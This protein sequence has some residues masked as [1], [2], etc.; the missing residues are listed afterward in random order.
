MRPWLH[1]FLTT[2]ALAA[3]PVFSICCFAPLTI[4]AG[5]AAEFWT[6]FPQVIGA[7]LP[8]A[9]TLTVALGV[10]GLLMTEEGLH[11]YRATLCALAILLWLQGN[12]L[13]WDYGVLDG[14]EIEWMSGAWRG[15]LDLAIWVA[16][17]LTAIYAYQRSGRILLMGAAATLLIQLVAAATTLISNPAILYTTN[18]ALHTA[19]R[20]AVMRFSATSNIVHIVMDGFQSDIFAEIIADTS[21]RNLQAD[22]QGFTYFDQNLG[23]YPYTQLTVPAMLSGKL[24]NNDVPVDE[25]IGDVMRGNT[26]VNTAFAAGYEVDIAAPISLINVYNQGRYTNAYGISSSGHVDVADYVR[27]DAAKLMDLALFRVVPHVGKALVYRDAL[28]VFQASAHAEAYLQMQYFSDLAFL[29][30]L[31]EGMSVDRDVPVYKMIHVMLSHRPFVGNEQ[32]E[33]SGRKSGSRENVRTHA[34]CGLLRVLDVLQRM[35]ELGIYKSSLIVLMADH[36]AWVP[37][38][39]LAASDVVKPLTVAMATPMLAIKPPG[40]DNDFQT[41]NVP[42]SVVDVPATIADLAGFN[43][44][45]DGMALF[46]VAAD[47]P[48]KRQHRVYGYGINPAAVGYLF[49]MQEYVIDGSPYDSRAW[50]KGRRYLPGGTADDTADVGRNQ[51]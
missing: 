3:I 27:V 40:A 35:K 1:R 12:I 21:E 34:R 14:S 36:G 41:S 33:F 23:A 46:S 16:V 44:Q 39:N 2:T 10:L 20:D 6:S 18:V 38:E 15:V 22:L 5:N 47:A 26:I 30:E 29:D 7:F 43:G 50:Q 13:V 32:C 25:F 45:F 17:L 11:R 37:V 48:R 4:Y 51:N 31:A 8:Y 49:P 24:F 42:S 28:W 19:G 9:V